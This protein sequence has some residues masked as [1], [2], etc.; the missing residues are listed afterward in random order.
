MMVHKDRNMQEISI[1]YTYVTSTVHLVGIKRVPCFANTNYISPTL[2]FRNLV[3]FES[4]VWLFI[5]VEPC[6]EMSFR[7]VW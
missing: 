7:V 6:L 3:S 4:P 5:F 2:H 1:K